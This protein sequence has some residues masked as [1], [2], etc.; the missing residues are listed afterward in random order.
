MLFL[1]RG[2]ADHLSGRSGLKPL[3]AVLYERAWLLQK[4]PYSQ[5]S[6]LNFADLVETLFFPLA[7]RFRMTGC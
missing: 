4:V 1:C 5:K 6:V 2:L 7:E 3:A